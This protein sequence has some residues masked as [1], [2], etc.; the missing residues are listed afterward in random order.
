MAGRFVVSPCNDIEGRRRR[1]KSKGLFLSQQVASVPWRSNT[2]YDAVPCDVFRLCP[3]QQPQRKLHDDTAAS[4]FPTPI[5]KQKNPPARRQ[6]HVGVS[7]GP[8][9]LTCCPC[10]KSHGDKE[11]R[12]EGLCIHG[13]KLCRRGSVRW[14]GRILT[15]A[16]A[17]RAHA[18]ERWLRVRCFVDGS[19]ASRRGR[20]D[21][22]I[23]CPRQRRNRSRWPCTRRRRDGRTGIAI[24]R[25]AYALRGG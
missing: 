9:V 14:M 7:H 24:R 18:R 17:S 13:T 6:R 1:T 8:P 12:R 20:F 3:V 10:A 2:S 22:G 19:A 21:L 23:G 4:N 16:V 5:T 15:R 25:D 11:G